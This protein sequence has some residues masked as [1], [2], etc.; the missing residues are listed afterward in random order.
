MDLSKRRNVKT[1][2][3]FVEKILSDEVN[4]YGINTT[5][6]IQGFNVHFKVKIPFNNEYP[7]P[8]GGYPQILNFKNCGFHENFRISGSS[9]NLRFECSLP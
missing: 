3:E 9:N 7:F 5:Y 6:Q 2:K 1:P 8:N 4:N